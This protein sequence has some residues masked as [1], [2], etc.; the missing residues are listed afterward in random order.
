LRRNGIA[1]IA[2]ASKGRNIASIRSTSH[3][4]C[5]GSIKSLTFA[6]GGRIRGGDIILPEQFSISQFSLRMF[7]NPPSLFSK[8][9][10]VKEMQIS[11]AQSTLIFPFA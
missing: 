10:L 4:Y 11:K 6:S 3:L 7:Q 2:L 8:K 1:L 9:S 5:I